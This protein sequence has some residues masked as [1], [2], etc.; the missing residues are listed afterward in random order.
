MTTIASDRVMMDFDTTESDSILQAAV[1]Q[2]HST[3]ESKP[4]IKPGV[5]PAET[6]ILKSDT[7]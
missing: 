7:I 5:D 6:R 2:G 4:V 3:M 1:A